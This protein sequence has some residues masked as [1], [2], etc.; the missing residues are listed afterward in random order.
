MNKVVVSLGIAL[1]VILGAGLAAW[2]F[3]WG[4]LAAAD[5]DLCDIDGSVEDHA[6]SSDAGLNQR[7]IHAL[8][9]LEPL[10]GVINLGG[11][12]GDRVARLLVK[13]GDTVEPG[14]VLAELASRSLR[15]LEQE[16]IEAQIAE[17]R[18]RRRAEQTA[19][20]AR[21]RLAELNLKKARSRQS[22]IAAQ[23]R[24]VSLAQAN[25]DVAK[26][27]LE[28]IQGLSAALVS[29]QELERQRLLV[30]KAEAELAAA[31]AAHDVAIESAR[32]AEEAALAELKTAQ[33][34]REQVLSAI[35]LASLEKQRE[36]A[37]LQVQQTQVKA[38]AAGT[39]LEVFTHEGE[40]LANKPILQLA[41]LARLICV[42]EVYEGDL[43]RVAVGQTAIVAGHAF[44]ARIRKTGVR[45]VVTRIGDMISTPEL[46][47]ID[48]FAPSDRHV[49]EVFIALD[50]NALPDA[51]R[52]ANLQVEVTILTSDGER[53][54]ENSPGVAQSRP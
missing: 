1:V 4:P 26:K 2:R 30:Q 37:A 13:P 29:K 34:G 6:R 40:V 10:G 49:V 51:A 46:R 17:A 8:G 35:P 5:G 52:L 20:D 11:M 27:D 19:A 23:E 33:A 47:A 16:A 25:L 50:K 3:G 45:G 31:V 12:V 9:R 36:L 42:A 15:T 39:V 38:P 41:N 21:V 54:D 32:F 14:Q 18:A 43:P 7:D 28:R 24:Q 22:E 48:P 44:P 53:N